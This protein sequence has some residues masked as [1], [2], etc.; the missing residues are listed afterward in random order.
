MKKVIKKFLII[1]L[2]VLLLNNFIYG[3]CYANTYPVETAD[4]IV[5]FLT[6]GIGILVAV[7]T[8]PLRLVAI[9][10]GYAVNAL[11]AKIAY[12]DKATE[13]NSV[14]TFITPFDIFFNKVKLFEINFFDIK[15]DGLIIS[16]VRA[17]VAGWYYVMRT[18]AAAILLVILIYVGIRMAISTVASDRAMYKRMLVDW[19]ASLALIFILQYIMIF[20]ISANDAIVNAISLVVDSEEISNVYHVIAGMAIPNEI[21]LKALKAII[22]LDSLA[23]TVIFCMLVWQTLGLVFS[24]FNRMLKLAFLVIISP[25]I[26]LTYSIDKMGDGKAQALGT[27]LK[28]FVFTILI[29]PFHC[30]IYMCFIDAAFDLLVAKS[31]LGGL[32]DG[33]GALAASIVAILC[34]KFTKEGEKIVRKIFAFKD[35]N[36][37]TSLAGGMAAATMALSQAKNL[38]K[39]ARNTVNTAKAFGKNISNLKRN[40]K[41]ERMAVAAYMADKEG[42]KDF[43][44]YKEEASIKVNEKEAEKA[45][46]KTHEKYKLENGEFTKQVNE[47]LARVKD[48]NPG[49]SNKEAK[50]IAQRNVAQRARKNGTLRGRAISGVSRAKAK[51]SNTTVGKAISEIRNSETAKLAKEFTKSSVNAGLGLMIGSGA[52]GTGGNIATAITSGI[53][54]SKGMGEFMSGSKKNLAQGITQNLMDMGIKDSATARNICKEVQEDAEKYSGGDKSKEELKKIIDEIKKAAEKNGL[55]ESKI[56]EIGNNVEQAFNNP[57]TAPQAIKRMLSSN[58]ISTDEGAGK[59]LLDYSNKRAIYNQMQNAEAAGITQSDLIE[60]VDKMFSSSQDET[61]VQGIANVAN[62]VS[63]IGEHHDISEEYDM[64]KYD[65]KEIR[66]DIK[67]HDEIIK[68][69]EEK[70]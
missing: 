20:T 48:L 47:E 64:S 36:S 8:L 49:M 27:W 65:L 10:A 42:K 18:L 57:L 68:D 51:V 61:T 33:G 60:S 21:S 7:L 35:D 62:D 38:G 16:Q 53:A 63:N 4:D 66:K 5:D 50:A 14:E 22:S 52:Y 43:S 58:S 26:S 30:V 70:N 19:V 3:A 25:L 31:G 45:I 23:A 37:T 17:S 11:T 69:Y 28:E 29:Q 56:T 12:V 55:E 34:V 40:V 15:D 32:T 59:K 44:E 13:G 46:E 1:I 54:M 41:I 2:I 67:E 39:K 24:Y 9:G 6:G